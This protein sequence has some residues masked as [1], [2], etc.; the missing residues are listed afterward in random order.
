MRHI[1]FSP[2]AA[3]QLFTPPCA[4]ASRIVPSGNILSDGQLERRAVHQVKDASFVFLYQPLTLQTS[5]FAGETDR[6]PGNDEAA[7]RNSASV[8]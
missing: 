8:H 3:L 6:E 7:L 2:P 5:I 1:A 4:A